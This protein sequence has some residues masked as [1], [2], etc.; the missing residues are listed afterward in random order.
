MV[1]NETHGEINI[2][3][4]PVDGIGGLGLVAIAGF[5]TYNIPALRWAGFIAMIGGLAIGLTLLISRRHHVR[6]TAV[7]LMVLLA[8]ALVGAVMLSHSD[9]RQIG[10]S[11]PLSCRPH[12]RGLTARYFS[13][14]RCRHLI[15]SNAIASCDGSISRLRQIDA[16]S[17]WTA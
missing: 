15:P 5:V 8:A 9:V 3:K 16:R 4:I 6:R 17:V 7:V 14:T 1:T 11:A 10:A 13:R 12:S 2:S